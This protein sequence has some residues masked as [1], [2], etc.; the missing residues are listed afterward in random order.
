MTQTV[1]ILGGNGKIGSHAAEA[2]WNAGW[3]VRHY[4]RATGDMTQ[5]AQ[6][7]DVIVNGLNPPM[8]RNWAKTIPAITDQVIAAA[9]ASGATVIIPGNIYNFGQVT[10]ELSEETPHDPHTRK[11]KIRV[12]MEETYRAAGVRT[13]ILRAGSFIDPNGNGDIMSAMIMR[14]AKSR[15]VNVPGDPEAMQAYAYVPDWGR[16]AVMIAEKRDQLATFEDIPFPG[17]SFT[18][19]QF[20][21]H[22]DATSGQHF[23]LT[24]FPWW[25]I[26]LA[27]PFVELCRELWE[28][29][30]QYD[31]DHWIGSEK[32]DR[33]LPDFKPTPIEQ[34]MSA[35]LSANVNPDKVMHTRSQPI[36]AE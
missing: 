12:E 17:H 11:G 4:D 20:K 27:S 19:N 8:Y 24:A 30:Y 35:A 22:L 34:V 13:I 33:L 6:G 31:M 26:R 5:A 1:L 3:N 14:S 36:V 25:M 23:K 10:G 7:A 18:I 21:A 9:K 16:A 29:R 28:M 2:F 32:F 15:K